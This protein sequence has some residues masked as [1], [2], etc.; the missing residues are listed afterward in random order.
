MLLSYGIPQFAMSKL[1]YGSTIIALFECGMDIVI[2][3]NDNNSIATPQIIER[4]PHC[5]VRN[6]EGGWL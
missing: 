2:K 4:L 3:N 1:T 6:E 5:G